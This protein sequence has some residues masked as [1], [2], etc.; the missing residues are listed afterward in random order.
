[1]KTPTILYVAPIT[2]EKIS[3]LTVSI[4]NTVRA[5]HNRGIKVALLT[6]SN[7]GPYKKDMPFPVFYIRN[8]NGK[9]KKLCQLPLPFSKPDIII[10][11]STYIPIH[12]SLAKEANKRGIPYVI[13]PRGGM[14]IGAQ[15]QKKVK[16][17]IG[18]FLFFNRMVKN[19]VAIHCL[20]EAES[21][22]VSKWRTETF[23]VGNGTELV[24]A[25]VLSDT[26]S[27]KESKN[28]MNFVF[29]GRLDI[30]HKGLDL[31]IE[32]CSKIK[33]QLKLMNVKVNLYGPDINNSKKE[34][35]RLIELN[36]LT[37]II[38][39]HGPVVGS[40]KELI[41]QDADIFVHTSR[42]EGHPMSVLEAMSYGIPCLVT[43]GTNILDEV[44][45]K[46]VGWGTSFDSDN[47]AQ[48]LTEIINSKENVASYG[49]RAKR[50]IKEKYTWDRVAEQLLDNFYGILKIK[51]E[52]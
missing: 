8:D 12:F 19:A 20:N 11:Q 28:E 45:E 36:S 24:E 13:T 41:L 46:K 35:E 29:I 26:K 43:P 44:V 34:L 5:L 1:M 39:V 9:L 3:G 16:K 42:F 10:F 21:K 15:S 30:Y 31:L 47:I 23:V 7:K 50:L 40:D 33:K 4:P 51:K 2:D 52:N 48:V 6:T 49:T 32:G 27:K 17:K 37:E 22:D 18:N 14:T 25:K 38:N